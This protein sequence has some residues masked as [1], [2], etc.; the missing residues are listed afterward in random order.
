LLTPRPLRTLVGCSDGS[1]PRPLCLTVRIQ[2]FPQTGRVLPRP[3][4]NG[5]A[6]MAGQTGFPCSPST[7]TCGQLV[8]SLRGPAKA[9]H[10]QRKERSTFPGPTKPFLEQK[11][12]SVTYCFSHVVR[13]LPKQTMAGESLRAHRQRRRERARPQAKIP[14]VSGARRHQNYNEGSS[15]HEQQPS[16]RMLCRGRLAAAPSPLHISRTL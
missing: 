7:L 15:S 13:A 3:C 8:L 1:S 9:C 2:A 4:P 10:L 5:T 16:V 12:N 6:L 11:H 14:S